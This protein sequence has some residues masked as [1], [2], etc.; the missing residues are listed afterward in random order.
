MLINKMN[1]HNKIYPNV[2]IAHY[3]IKN[4][5]SAVDAPPQPQ[6]DGTAPTFSKKPTIRQVGRHH[7]YHRYNHHYHQ[8]LYRQKYD[9][10]RPSSIAFAFIIFVTSF[11]III[12]SIHKSTMRSKSETKPYHFI[13]SHSSIRNCGPGRTIFQRLVCIIQVSARF[14][15]D[16]RLINHISDHIYTH[17][18]HSRRRTFSQSIS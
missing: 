6:V 11:I 18:N 15:N 16:S 2:I 10:K 4:I 8:H 7:H 13:K 14:L 3:L 17:R 12:A 1:F 5:C 9:T